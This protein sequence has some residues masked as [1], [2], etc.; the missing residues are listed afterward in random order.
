MTNQV[1]LPDFLI[2]LNLY[3]QE[4]LQQYISLLTFVNIWVMIKNKENQMNTT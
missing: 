2:Q 1:Y 4:I 3:F